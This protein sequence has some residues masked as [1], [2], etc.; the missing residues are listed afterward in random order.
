MRHS[1]GTSQWFFF[2]KKKCSVILFLALQT[3]TSSSEAGVQYTLDNDVVLWW[4]PCSSARITVRPLSRSAHLRS[5]PEA[6][7]HASISIFTEVQARL[8][9]YTSAQQVN[10]VVC[11]VPPR[12]DEPSRRIHP[13]PREGGCTLLPTPLGT[14]AS[15]WIHLISS[16][17]LFQ[18][19][20][21]LLLFVVRRFS[22]GRRCPTTLRRAGS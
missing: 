10:E 21:S 19:I 4:R 16:S 7:K 9:G 18:L 6:E 12:R 14:S 5:A 13:D 2:V 1:S 15:A 3:A 11:F 20:P 17:L 22:L 8:Q